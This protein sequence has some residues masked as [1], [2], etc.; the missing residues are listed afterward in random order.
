MAFAVVTAMGSCV[1]EEFDASVPATDSELGLEH[2][3]KVTFHFT[4]DFGTLLPDGTKAMADK[5]Q[6]KNVYFA[7]FDAAGYKL[8]EY[9]EAVPDKCADEN[10]PTEFSYSVDLTITDQP[11]ILHILANAPTSLSYGS[12]S[13][14][15]GSLFSKYDADE[16]S[17][18]Q[19]AYWQR[20]E[21]PGV[22]AKPDPSTSET[23]ANYAT[24]LANYNR[25]V[26]ILGT[27]ELIRNFAKVTVHKASSGCDDFTLTGFWLTNI[28]SIGSFAPYN[29]TT[30]EFVNHYS[31][32]LTIEEVMGSGD[33]ERGSTDPKWVAE[34]DREGNVLTDGGG[35]PLHLQKGNYQGFFPANAE[36]I[37][38]D[39]ITGIDKSVA[40]GLKTTELWTA[41]HIEI[42][43]ETIGAS[44]YCYEREIPKSNPMY[45]I[46]S[47]VYHDD[48]DLTDDIETFYK[49][50]LRDSK[51]KYF[52][53]LR[54]FNYN[55]NIR[56]VTRD[57]ELTVAAAL[58]AAPSGDISTSLDL[59]GLTNM[60]DGY[61]QMFV[62]ETERVIVGTSLG[63]NPIQWMYKFIPDISH[64]DNVANI[65]LE[66]YLDGTVASFANEEALQAH[67]SHPSYVTFKREVQGD[68][69]LDAVFNSL[70]ILKSGGSYIEDDGYYTVK[71]YPK[72]ASSTIKTE[73]VTVTGHYYNATTGI[74]RY[75][76]V[77][78]QV[79]FRLREILDMDVNVNPST[80]TKASGTQVDLSIGL[81][82]GLPSSIFSLNMTIEAQKNNLTP[83]N[84][85]TVP[86][87]EKQCKDLPISTG[88]SLFDSSQPGY[89]FTR[90]IT[91][92][93]Y[94]A[95][96]IVDGKKWFKCYFKTS[97]ASFTTTIIKVSNEYF[98]EGYTYFKASGDDS[99]FFS[100]LKFT[101]DLKIG[102]GSATDFS[103][104]MTSDAD[105]TVKIEGAAEITGDAL[106]SNNLT[107][108]S[109][110][111]STFTYTYSP[112]AA[113]IQTIQG[114]VAS[115]Y[116]SGIT[117]TLSATGYTAVNK[118]RSRY[119]ILSA[120]SVTGSGYTTNF[121]VTSWTDNKGTA[122]VTAKLQADPT[123]TFSFPVEVTR[124][125]NGSMTIN[126]PNG[127][128]SRSGS[129]GNR[130]YTCTITNYDD[131][132]SSDDY[133]FYYYTD[134]PSS[135]LTLGNPASLNGS[136]SFVLTG[137]GNS[138]NIYIRAVHHDTGISSNWSR[139]RYNSGSS[140]S[141]GEARTV[142]KYSYS[143][144]GPATDTEVEFNDDE[145]TSTSKFDV[146][147]STT[148]LDKEIS[149]SDLD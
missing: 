97:T 112:D 122:T 83:D 54:N 119:G 52:P 93:E 87:S 55:I 134:N 86:D 64:P 47:G 69:T 126:A 143:F 120:N 18:W 105:V 30:K 31:D 49:I 12:E 81:E 66:C 108:V 127:A 116:G 110:S 107:K 123:V 27:P 79:V 132:Y 33:V 146:Y 95:A 85:R 44:S 80:V 32:Y 89:Q 67:S 71:L 10:A 139:Y 76:S 149:V 77:S 9:A 58:A 75:E 142:T 17:E 21:L 98:N 136:H 15:I 40:E 140:F 90:T 78:R 46:I 133:D 8:S 51:D 145:I 114:L 38:I 16:S 111:G 5:P 2:D 61:G 137:Q 63:T 11:R 7:L 19:D 26:K 74:E 92:S 96:P 22:Y 29:R 84:K 13:E 144:S 25:I 57:G 62:S 50:D 109:G 88:S 60:S 3:G 106:T 36:L 128:I 37:T 34:T 101:S 1:N 94:E 73:T 4:P 124:T 102:T 104:F 129:S 138:I 59:Q 28:P 41:H 131:D 35:N 45:I 14:V 147:Y 113:G 56:S 53:I 42:T 24:K 48:G 72:A 20:I 99:N 117:V 39:G 43:D 100:A 141:R 121:G 91:W 68:E 6:V 135:D 148:D 115:T 82:P 65:P 125:N 130:T 103:F 118:T 23:D 70:E